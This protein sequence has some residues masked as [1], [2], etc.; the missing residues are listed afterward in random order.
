MLYSGLNNQHWPN[1]VLISFSIIH[2]VIA[3]NIIEF[4]ITVPTVKGR[5]ESDF[6]ALLLQ[7]S[8]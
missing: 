6:T 8:V 7:N 3:I 2:I 1:Q 4:K 5:D